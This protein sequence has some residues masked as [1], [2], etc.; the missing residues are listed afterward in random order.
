MAAYESSVPPLSESEE[1]IFLR[2]GFSSDE[3]AKWHARDI[4]PYSA[5]RFVEMGFSIDQAAA[6]ASVGIGP[7]EAKV[8]AS[9]GIRIEDL[10]RWAFSKGDAAMISW[11]L[12]RGLTSEAMKEVDGVLRDLLSMGA[13]FEQCG[14]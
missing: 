5:A 1:R 3:A 2:H 7:S 14:A 13:T 9:R 4:G 12:D 10:S 6:F 8:L 11:A